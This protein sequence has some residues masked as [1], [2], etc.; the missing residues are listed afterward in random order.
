MEWKDEYSVGHEQIDSE[1]RQFIKLITRLE[2][3]NTLTDKTSLFK[4]L[5]E[6]EAYTRFHF[7]N[8]EN[9]MRAANRIMN[10][11][12]KFCIF[13]VNRLSPDSS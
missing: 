6:L 10:G 5:A 1:H 2:E 11:P 3:L 8:E 9:T 4:N 13:V 12:L 7:T